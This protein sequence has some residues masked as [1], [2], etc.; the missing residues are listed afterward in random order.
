VA[1]GVGGDAPPTSTTAGVCV[2]VGGEGEV[3]L[4]FL[5]LVLVR[6]RSNMT[7][8]I[9]SMALCAWRKLCWC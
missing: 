3:R 7:E 6:V 2:C 4:A 8:V 1:G 5:V 9:D